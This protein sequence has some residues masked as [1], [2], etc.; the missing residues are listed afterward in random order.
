LLEGANS[1]AD[2]L[3]WQGTPLSHQEDDETLLENADVFPHQTATAR[4]FAPQARVTIGPMRLDRSQPDTYLLPD[5]RHRGL[6][7]AAFVA[8]SLRALAQARVDLAV[9]FDA[10]GP[11]GHMDVLSWPPPTDIDGNPR[12]HAFPSYYVLREFGPLAGSET[13][14][15]ECSDALRV[16]AFGVRHPA[17]AIV[18][19]INQ[20]PEAQRASLSGIY[21]KGS[22]VRIRSL[23]EA[24]F[25][26]LATRPASS[27]LEFPERRQTVEADGLD[28]AM[29]AFSVAI[30]MGSR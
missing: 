19:V 23:D 16:K 3:A 18:V 10:V 6:L 8:S 24:T 1:G 2:F 20:T 17:G 21:E 7:A 9:F 5:P 22:V 25:P 14:E 15:V 11:A 13:F 26:T 27:L 30:L 28:L 29:P 4:G 12:P